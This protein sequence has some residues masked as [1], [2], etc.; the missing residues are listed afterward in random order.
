MS[1]SSVGYETS[2]ILAGGQ[3]SRFG[4]LGA[5]LPKCLLSIYDQPVLFRQIKLCALAGARRVVVSI[6]E[7]YG[8]L[9]EAVLALYTPPP[10]VTVECVREQRPLG[11]P[12][13]LSV[14]APLVRG[15][16]CLVMLGDAY[17]ASDAPFRA[18]GAASRSEQMVVAITRD[19]HPSRIACNVVLTDAGEV[20]RINE[21]PKPADLVGGA[22]WSCFCALQAGVLDRAG[23]L[24]E[25]GRMPIPYIGDLFEGFR[26]EGVTTGTIDVP[27]LEMNVNTVDDLVVATLFEARRAALSAP[28][29]LSALES[30]LIPLLR[31]YGVE[32]DQCAGADVPSR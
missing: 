10:G 4:E 26:R 18:L 30:A 15:S 8:D 31:N 32:L 20:E 13:G 14:L 3:G 24:L 21:K 1:S 27:E 6:A 28:E 2:I 5:L 29:K 7:R 11:A 19:S 23:E 22:R 25:S 17:F 9:L 16:G 12:K